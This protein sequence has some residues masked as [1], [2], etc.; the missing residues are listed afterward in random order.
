[1]RRININK[2]MAFLIITIFILLISGIDV[3]R[4][5]NQHWNI[6]NVYGKWKVTRLIGAYK[7]T[8]GD[9]PYGSNIGR[10][11]IITDKNIKDSTT[12]QDA[13]EEADEQRCFSMKVQFQKENIFD[14]T[15]PNIIKELQMDFGLVLWSAGI[16]DN[17]ILQYIFYSDENEFI[18]Q[19]V[20]YCM[21]SE[22]EV[23]SY[24]QE[25]KDK[26]IVDLPMGF[27][28]L[29]RFKKQEK[30]EI[31]YGL[32]MVENLI[33]RGREEKYGIA[34]YDYY[35]KCFDIAE[36]YVIDDE[37]KETEINWKK[38]LVSKDTFE[39]EYGIHEGLGLEDDELEVWY[40]MGKDNNII[41]LI[42]INSNEIIMPLKEQWF[43]L[44]KIPQYE[45]PLEKC[46][47][48]LSGD[49]KITQL[50]GTGNVNPDI[51]I[52]GRSD[53]KAWWYTQAITFNEDMYAANAVTDWEIREYDALT[54]FQ[55]FNVP[56]NITRLF[57]SDDILHIGIRKSYDV[58][59]MYIVIDEN[60]L[61][62]E[63]NGLWY[64]LERMD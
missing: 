57:N 22:F 18:N 24:R 46:E 30:G 48:V 56:K 14:V 10:S 62:R 26:L 28:I 16:T 9:M 55:E 29:E 61:I 42:P 6:D 12:I 31:P 60:T 47:T 64:K 41:Q 36:D 43:L 21:A 40:G 15:R 2:Y 38:T 13:I 27:Y 17:V 49:W 59:E 3:Y 45:E 32:W 58:E 19:N 54:F 50:I 53:Y 52:C 25:D 37:G 20:N 8:K 1:M 44:T 35:G 33:S 5:D 11:F 63:R 51:E 23:L 4:S 39:Q 7:G 34:F